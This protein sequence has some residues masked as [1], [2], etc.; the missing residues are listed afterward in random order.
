MTHFSSAAEKRLRSD[1]IAWLTTVSPSGM[2]QSSPV[3]FLW[4]GETF[5]IYSQP[6]KPKV[7]NVES[8]P[9]VSLHLDGDGRGG[10]I[11]TIEGTARI[12][13]DVPPADTIAA[14]AEKYAAGI[15]RLGMDAARFAADYSV[16]IRI[17]P[18]RARAWLVS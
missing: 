9:K 4:D 10:N 6:N 18:L 14:Y 2:P 3:W 15:R 16:A 12:D 17:S 1:Q 11:V 7:R 13:G 5:L 8:H